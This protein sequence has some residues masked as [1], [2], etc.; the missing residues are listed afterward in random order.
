MML[1]SGVPLPAGENGVWGGVY[2]FM[3]TIPA[4]ATIFDKIVFHCEWQPN[5]VAIIL[6][7]VADD[8]SSVTEL[9]RVIVHQIPE[10]ATMLL[11]GLGGLFLRRRK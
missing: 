6:Y 4:G 7:Q 8:M 2:T 1:C 11:L 5:D 9:D 10:P 3:Y